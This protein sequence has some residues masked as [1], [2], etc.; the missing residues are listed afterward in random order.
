MKYEVQPV[1][2][3][4]GRIAAQCPMCEYCALSTTT[5]YA[6]MNRLIS[7]MNEQYQEKVWH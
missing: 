4:S 5:T 3:K 1:H 6:A 7:H 2:A